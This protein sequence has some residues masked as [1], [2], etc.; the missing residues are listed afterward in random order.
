MNRERQSCSVCG[1]DLREEPITYTQTIGER[2]YV[3]TEVPAQVCPIDGEQYLSPD[4]VDVIQ[5]VIERGREPMRT[6]EVP[7]YSY[8]QSTASR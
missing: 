7:V 3:V 6:I 2:L 1:S 5:E 8:P 4:V